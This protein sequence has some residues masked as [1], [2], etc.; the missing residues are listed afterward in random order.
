MG[1]VGALHDRL[2]ISRRIEV[3]ATWFARLAPNGARILDVGCGDGLLSAQICAKRPDLEI[4]GI[5]VLPRDRPYIPVEIFDGSRIPFP[6]RSFD[7]VLFSDVLH[8]T[9]DPAVLLREARRVAGQCVLIKD[10]YCKGFAAAKRLRFMDWVGNS[11]FGVALPYNYWKET[12]WKKAWNEIGLTPEE[13][14]E[15]LGLY[16]FPANLIFGSDLHFVARLKVADRFTNGH[17]SAAEVPK[18]S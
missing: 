8:H 4:H 16:R 3:L 14:I 11:R 10:H 5:D 7:A 6:D 13:L 17:F 1:V 18:R 9:E 15:N 2:V 12:Q